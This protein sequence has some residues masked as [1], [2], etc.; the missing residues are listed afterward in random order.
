MNPACSLVEDSSLG[1]RLPPSSSGCPRLPVSGEGWASPQQASCAQSSVP[2]ASLLMSLV[3]AFLGIAIPQSGKLS[4]VS[5]VRLPSGHVG[6]VLT[7]SNAAWA[8]FS[9]PWLLVAYASIWA[10]SLLGVTVRHIISF[11]RK[12]AAFL[13]A[14]CPLPA[15]RSFVEFAQL[16]NVLLMNL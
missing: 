5:S 4:Q 3:R 15:F 6:L 9:S 2:W 14:W 16:S 13:G 11:L 8:S 12:W 10:A 1:S 7:L